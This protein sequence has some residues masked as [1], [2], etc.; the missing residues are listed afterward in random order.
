MIN[1]FIYLI[2]QVVSL[3]KRFEQY[4]KYESSFS[5]LFTSHKLRSLNDTTNFKF[6]SL[7]VVF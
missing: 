3:N 7:L 1:Y 2:N 4:Q 6:L 5:L